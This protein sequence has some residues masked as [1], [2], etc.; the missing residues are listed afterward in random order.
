MLNHLV[1]LAVVIGVVTLVGYKITERDNE[2]F[3][4][5]F[6]VMHALTLAGLAFVVPLNWILGL[7][8]LF[9]ISM[10]ITRYLVYN[11]NHLLKWVSY[12]SRAYK[13]G[14]V[15]YGEFFYP[16]SIIILVLLAHS[17]WEFAAA[18]LIL[19]LADTA[20]AMVGKKYGKR[21]TYTILGQ[22]KSFTG[23]VAFFVVCL[24]VLTGFVALAPGIIPVNLAFVGL[25]T[26]AITVSENVGVYGSDNLLIPVV[27]VVLLNAM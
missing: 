15:S 24:A 6:H 1:I 16:V 5:L 19:G 2:S 7:E 9:F 13:V 18:V 21:T 4:K 25:V 12:M 22:K 17:K 10:I 26:L 20:A 14:R 3:R 8:I 11:N 27:A 23:S